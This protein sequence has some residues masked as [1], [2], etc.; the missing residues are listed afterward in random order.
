VLHELWYA[1]RRIRRRPLQSLAIAATL[2]LGIGS[3]VAVFGAVDAVLLR[4][5]PFPEADRLVRVTQTIPVDGLPELPFSDVGYRRLIEENRTLTGAAAWTTRNA[6]LLRG[7]G[8]RR[9]TVAQVSASLFTVLRVRPAIGRAFSPDEDLPGGPRVIVLSHGLWQSDFGADSSI[10]GAVINLEGEPFVVIGVLGPEVVFPSRDVAAWEPLRLSATAVTPFQYAYTVIARLRAGANNEGARRDLTEPIR[11]VG[12]EYPGPHPG[13]AI[14]PA[15]YSA[16]VRSLADAMVGDVRPVVTLLLCGVMGLVLLTCANVVNLQLAAI[17]ARRDEFAVRTAIGASR[18]RLIGGQVIEAT[19]LAAAGAVLCVGVAVVGATLV[20]TV[21]PGTAS[22]SQFSGLTLVLTVAIV[23][24]VGLGVGVAPMLVTSSHRS[25]ETL[26]ARAAASSGATRLRR[27]LAAAQVAVAVV[28]L[29]GSGLLVASAARVAEVDLGFE[30]EGA[31]SLRL[32]IPDATLRDRAAREGLLRTLVDRARS[33]PGVAEAGIAN[34]LPLT[35][36]PRDLAM[37]VEGRPFK[38]DGT[39]P[40]ADFRIVSEGYFASMGIRVVR[41]RVFGDSEASER[42]TPLVINEALARRLFPDGEDPVGQ[43]LRFGPVAPWMPIVGVVADA[44]NRSL[45]E[46]PR[47]ELYTPALGSRSNLTLRSGLSLVVRVRGDAMRH[48]TTLRRLVAEVAPDVAVERVVT[49]Q[50]VVRESG[51]RMTATTRLMAWYAA[52]ALLIA[53]AGTYAVLSFLV[54]QRR[55][56]LAIRI[57]LGATSGS[58]VRLVVRESAALVGAGAAVGFIG[59]V[60][61]ARLL[62]GMVYGVGTFDLAVLF[63]VTC[64]MALAGASATVLPA[65]RALRADPCD[66]LRSP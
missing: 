65:R 40:L 6:N 10:V 53:V 38:A 7:S 14:D 15:G 31:V 23:L 35:P 18:R 59:A 51:A 9:L 41:G 34:G 24:A 17:I 5:L 62:A 30:P 25:S 37:A 55:N 1:L 44:K 46:A 45:T 27:G 39:D 22:T 47:P 61:T 8:T 49:P 36:G 26:R 42:V 19:V 63:G 52:A 29:H 12:R 66:A 43:R 60:A 2:G 16:T 20:E 32:N 11:S 54:V 33:L 57:A 64:L 3:A 56:E 4:P 21:L 58:I 13:T 48:G 50:E 28:L